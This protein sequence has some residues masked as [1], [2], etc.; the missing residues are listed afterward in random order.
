MPKA[1][2]TQAAIKDHLNR[3]SPA[4]KDAL[5][6]DL[7]YDMLTTLNAMV[8]DQATMRTRIN[9]MLTKLDADGGVTDAN[10]NSTLAIPALTAVAVKPPEQR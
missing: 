3:M 8:A 5:L 1:G 7:I 9:S 6:G 2:V 10:Y 4:A